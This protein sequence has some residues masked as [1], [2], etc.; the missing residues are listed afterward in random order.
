MAKKKVR[1]ERFT[2]TNSDAFVITKKKK[3]VTESLDVA[4]K[5][6]EKKTIK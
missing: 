6:I 1:P 5:V 4:I 2:E 3:S